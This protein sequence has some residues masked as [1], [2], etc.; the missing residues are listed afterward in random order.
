MTATH[1]DDIKF[2]GIQ[3]QQSGPGPSK[4]GA[5]CAGVANDGPVHKG[6]AAA[7]FSGAAGD[8]C[9]GHNAA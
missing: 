6:C 1:N 3:H 5:T 8:V 2:F 7:Y 9:C 4:W